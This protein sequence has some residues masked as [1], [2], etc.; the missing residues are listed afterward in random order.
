MRFYPHPKRATRN[1]LVGHKGVYNV[2]TSC[3][4]SV[5][6]YSCY[7]KKSFLDY[8]IQEPKNAWLFEVSLSQQAV[9]YNARCLCSYNDDYV[10]LDVVRKGRILHK[11]HK[12]FL[13]HPGIY[14]G[15]R[16][17]QTWKYEAK[18]WVR[19]FL[20]RNTP[21]VFLPLFRKIFV[22]LGGQSFVYI[23]QK[24]YKDQKDQSK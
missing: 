7:W 22:L 21:T 23:G 14:K 10:I 2:D 8:T 15:D 9:N 4:Y 24:R 1:E 5:N 3:D 13:K 19:T 18:L 16:E 12:Y 11:A 6:L 20:G 17:L